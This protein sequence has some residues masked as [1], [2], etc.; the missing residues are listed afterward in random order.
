MFGALSDNLVEVARLDSYA[1]ADLYSNVKMF[2]AKKK[3]FF[4]IRVPGHQYISMI[5]KAFTNR[6]LNCMTE[7]L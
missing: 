7:L 2:I 5:V 6:K 3:N 1:S 4:K